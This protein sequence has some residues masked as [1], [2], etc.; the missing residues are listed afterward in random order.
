M[1][2]LILSILTAFAVAS[3]DAW[4]KKFFSNLSPYEMLAYP[5]IY[6]FPM[7]A[8]T[9]AFV[10]VPPLDLTFFWCFVASLPLNGISFLLYMKAI[11]VSPLSLTLPYLAFT[12]AFM[13]VTGFLLLKELP[14]MWGNL[15]ILITC[16]GSYVINFEP[17]NWNLLAPMKAVRRETGSWLMLIVS[18]LFSFAA[19]VGKKAILH[20]SPVFFSLSF[21]AVLNLFLFV[22][23]KA[24]KKI[25]LNTFSQAPL[26]G[27]IA[28][29]LLFC[30]VLL[31]GWA[32][33]LTKAAYMISVKRLSVLF[34]IIYGAL[35]FKERNIFIRFFGALLMLSGAVLIMIKGH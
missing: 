7:F 34:G 2:W 1:L 25:D 13:I 5:L 28:G 3:Q 22:A 23:F 33:S 29:F 26:K 19:V 16:L 11:K 9:V 15:G 12:P 32:I 27:I 17:G 35:V 24:F 20:S 18:F 21:F 4:V 30:Q 10:P 6:S 31:H 8:V 14:N